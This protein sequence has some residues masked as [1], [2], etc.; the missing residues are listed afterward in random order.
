MN[1]SIKKLG[2]FVLLLT[3]L[4]SCNTGPTLQTYFVENSENKNFITGDLPKSLLSVGTT[5]LT[6]QEQEAYNAIEGLNFLV[7]KKEKDNATQYQTEIDKMKLILKDKSYQELMDFSDEA[8]KFSIKY[9]GEDNDIDEIIVFG[10]NPEFGFG[11]VRVLGD[12]MNTKQLMTLVS[13]ARKGDVD[14]SQLK[15][16][17]DFLK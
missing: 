5:N 17:M 1:S 13:V 10:H 2:L 11:V 7:Y 16:I 3:V 9:L 6:E 15:G 4:V 8:G 12:N 14:E